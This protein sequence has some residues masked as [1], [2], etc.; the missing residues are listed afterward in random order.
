MSGEK[1]LLLIKPTFFIFRYVIVEWYESPGQET[2][3][4]PAHKVIFENPSLGFKFAGAGI[5]FIG[6][7]RGLGL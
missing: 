4:S 5:C 6:G 3:A 7:I 1:R 2:E